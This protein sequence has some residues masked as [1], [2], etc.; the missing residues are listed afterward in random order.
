MHLSV[1]KNSHNNLSLRT[2]QT[3]V[4]IMGL[5]V[6]TFLTIFNLNYATD[7]NNK[8]SVVFETLETE[9][10]SGGDSF[11]HLVT[12]GRLGNQLFQYA[13]FYS[14]A[15]KLKVPLFLE[16]PTIGSGENEVFN[17]HRLHVPVPS[18]ETRKHFLQKVMNQPD[19]V[20]ALFDQD[21]L[22][23]Y[24]PVS[25]NK[26]LMFSKKCLLGK[27]AMHPQPFGKHLK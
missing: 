15:R 16:V 7:T 22:A 8:E 3:L 2:Y 14:L 17:L 26:D 12:F 6:V 25:L 24:Y 4:R 10:S 18:D 27:Y 11:V 20:F 19:K 9:A 5:I 1:K 13:C 23:G 21:I